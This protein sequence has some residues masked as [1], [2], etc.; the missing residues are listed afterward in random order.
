MAMWGRASTP[1]HAEQGS[2]TVFS[3][4]EIG[5]ATVSEVMDE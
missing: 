4:A 2:A 1:V 3:L 5:V